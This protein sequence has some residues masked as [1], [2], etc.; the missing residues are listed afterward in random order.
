MVASDKLRYWRENPTR[1]VWDNF[2]VT[3]DLWQEKALEAF[4]SKSREDLRISLQACA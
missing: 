3:P 4:V 1:F 2:G